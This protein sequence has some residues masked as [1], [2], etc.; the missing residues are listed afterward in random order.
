MVTSIDGFTKA[1]SLAIEASVTALTSVVDLKNPLPVYGS[2]TP[3]LTGMAI[4]TGGTP[5]N[6]AYYT[7]IGG[8]TA[9]SKGLLIMEGVVRF[10]TTGV[11]L[12]AATPLGIS[13]PAAYQLAQYVDS[14]HTIGQWTYVGAGGE[15]HNVVNTASINV[16]RLLADVI[17]GAK[18]VPTATSSTVPG[19]WAINESIHWTVACMGAKV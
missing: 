15:S 2:Y 10:G 16:L 17:S 14:K 9:G 13:F 6:T 1:R 12:P 19:T 11:T 4:G 7:W 8:S 18:R 3:T 5:I